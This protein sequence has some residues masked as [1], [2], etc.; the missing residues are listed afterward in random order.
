MDWDVHWCDKEWM[1]ETFDHVHLEHWQRVN[2][3][4]NT[5]ELTRKDLLVKNLKRQ[6]KQL[7]KDNRPREAAL[8]DF[9]PATYVLPG[10]YALFAEEFKRSGANAGTWIMKVRRV[11]HAR[12]SLGRP[13][14]RTKPCCTC[15]WIMKPIGRSQGKG[16]FLFTKLSQVR[17]LGGHRDHG[18]V[19]TGW[20]RWVRL[21][22]WYRRERVGAGHG[23][24]VASEPSVPSPLHH[25]APSPA[26]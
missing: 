8:Y 24:V 2:H 13:I 7:L 22:G 21:Y 6:R 16:I 26:L 15:T 11:T 12:G 4:R 9:W 1:Y 10:D 3:Y 18:P 14:Q 19:G 17:S 5:R 25:F 20:Y 23:T